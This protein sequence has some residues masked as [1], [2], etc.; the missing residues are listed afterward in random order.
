M[1]LW[2]EPMPSCKKGEVRTRSRLH[3]LSLGPGKRIPKIDKV[4]ELGCLCIQIC[5]FCL[6]I[7]CP[8]NI[9]YLSMHV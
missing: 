7:I 9:E 1:P 8:L 3:C 5:D 4:L 6:Q 2:S